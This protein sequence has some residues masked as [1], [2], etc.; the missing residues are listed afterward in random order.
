[1]NGRDRAPVAVRQKHR[2]TV[3]RRHRDDGLAP[4]TAVVPYRIR[5]R[6]GRKVSGGH[7][8]RA[9]NLSHPSQAEGV[10]T[11]AR[12]KATEIFLHV[13]GVVTPSRAQVHAFE[14]ASTDPTEPRREAGKNP[15]RKALGPFEHGRVLARGLEVGQRLLE[16]SRHGRN[17]PN[18][19]TVWTPKSEELGVEGV[20]T[21]PEGDLA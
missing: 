20:P 9:M 17:E 12:S 4:V 2:N 11:R 8:D 15:G 1:V 19:V 7:H 14:E 18:P 16:F 21:H 10:K 3:G 5:L 13:L 6:V